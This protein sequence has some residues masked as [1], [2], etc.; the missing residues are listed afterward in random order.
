M[1]KNMI[2]PT[3]NTLDFLPFKVIFPWYIY[4]I[5][6]E[7]NPNSFAVIPPLVCSMIRTKTSHSSPVS[8]RCGVSL[9]RV[10]SELSPDTFTVVMHAVSYYARH[11]Y[12]GTTLYL[13]IV[14]YEI[15]L[16]HSAPF[17]LRPS[18]TS[19]NRKN[20]FYTF[21]LSNTSRRNS[22]AALFFSWQHNI[23]NTVGQVPMTLWTRSCTTVSRDGVYML[24]AYF[25]NFAWQF[26]STDCEFLHF[27]ALL[28]PQLYVWT[29]SMIKK[30]VPV[31][32][33]SVS[34][35]TAWREYVFGKRV[36]LYLNVPWV[37]SSITGYSYAIT[38]IPW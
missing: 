3:Q 28:V 1:S 30:C 27:Y 18:G 33:V 29:R 24:F 37:H 13:A 25:W 31:P 35:V 10:I 9:V 6:V 20:S 15:I 38:G 8:L 34:M 2:F 17:Y 36:Y 7:K 11:R 26:I 22:F 21:I 4:I 19:Q 14:A 12:N 5:I 16:S 23:K 32:K